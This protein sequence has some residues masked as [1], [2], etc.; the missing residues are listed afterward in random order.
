MFYLRLIVVFLFVSLS[1]W[2]DALFFRGL[3]P[4]SIVFSTR[5]YSLFLSIY[6]VF[7]HKR[8]IINMI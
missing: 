6:S 3:S 5:K 4:A 1:A 2:G 7:A 8:F